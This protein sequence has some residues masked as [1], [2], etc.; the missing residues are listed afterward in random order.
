MSSQPSQTTARSSTS[1]L[2]APAR[3]KKPATVLTSARIAADIAAF[4]KRGGKIEKL[5]VTPYRPYASS[6]FRSRASAQRQ[7]A[8]ATAAKKTASS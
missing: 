6:A 7:A 3:G 5:G 4:K 2:F 8:G 1:R